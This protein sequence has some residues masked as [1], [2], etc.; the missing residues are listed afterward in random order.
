MDD[1]QLLFYLRCFTF[2]RKYTR[3]DRRFREIHSA[4]E[5]LHRTGQQRRRCHNRQSQYVNQQSSKGNFLIENIVEVLY[6]F[7]LFLSGSVDMNMGC[8]SCS[9]YFVEDSKL[10]CDT[11]N[12]QQFFP[13]LCKV[14]LSDIFRMERI[15][16]SQNTLFSSGKYSVGK[17]RFLL[18]TGTIIQM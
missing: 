5:R 3:H 9:F 16:F 7:L 8:L 6:D 4:T 12:L 14:K 15:K 18:Y 17:Q 1:L 2:T 11:L 10:Q 13:F